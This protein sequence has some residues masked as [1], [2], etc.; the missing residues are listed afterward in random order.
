MSLDEVGQPDKGL[1]AEEGL[2]GDGEDLV[3]LL[4]GQLL[5][6]SDKAEDHDPGDEVEPSIEAKGTGGCHNRLHAGEGEGENT[7]EGVVDADGPG[8]AL[9][10]LDSGEDLGRVLEGNG[11]LAKGVGDGEEVDEAVSGTMVS[12]AVFVL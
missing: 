7:G 12:D 6:L 8:H 1:V 2:G 10:T 3:Q 11:A 9:L 4:E 5:G